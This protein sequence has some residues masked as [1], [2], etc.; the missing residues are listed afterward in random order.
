LQ[1]ANSYQGRT[2][3]GFPQTHPAK[4]AKRAVSKER[5]QFSTR[6]DYALRTLRKMVAKF[7]G[8]RRVWKGSFPDLVAKAIIMD[9]GWCNFSMMKFQ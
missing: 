4:P 5:K 2:K 1:F 9:G 6:I 7:L 8:K 3:L